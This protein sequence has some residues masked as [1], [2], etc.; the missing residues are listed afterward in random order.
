LALPNSITIDDALHPVEKRGIT[1]DDALAARDAATTVS[2][3]VPRLEATQKLAND[4]PDPR[5]LDEQG[6]GDTSVG[7]DPFVKTNAPPIQP[8]TDFNLGARIKSDLVEDPQTKRKV[9]AKSLFPNDPNG[10]TRIGFIDDIPVFVND[11]GQL[12]RVAPKSS[13]F[14]S[15]VIANAPEAIAGV[16][17][18]LSGMPVVGA[19]LGA[20][21][22]HG[23]K[24]AIAGAVFDEPQT[25]GGNLRG[26]AGEGVLNAAAGLAGKG[27]ASVI[28]RGKIV[29]FTPADVK[30]AEQARVLIKN[31]TGIDVD[32][33][34]ASGNNKLIA[35]RAYAA[36]YPGKSAELVQ[37]SEEA[38]KGQLD[39]AVNRVLNQIATTSPAEVAGIK[40]INAAGAVIELA[41]GARDKAVAPLYE[42]AG[43]N[44]LSVAAVEDLSFDPLVSRAAQQV[45]N[46]PVYQRKLTGM[47]S[48]SVAYWHQVKRRLDAGYQTATTSGNKTAARE[49]ADAA[50]KLNEKLAAASPE[51]KAANEAYAKAT[52]DTIEPLE[53]SAIGVLARVKDPKAATVAARIFND[54]NITASEIR[55][56][57]T[58][59]ENQDPEAW[60]GLVRQ[61]I[62][63]NWNKALK[64]T[65][66]GSAVNPA[67][68]LRQALVGTPGD[69][70]KAAAMMPTGALQAFEDL[71]N[72]AK[73]LS[74]TPT[75]GSNTMRDT[76]IGNQLKG[77]G[78]VIFKWLTSP[79]AA[80]ANAAEQRAVDKNTLALTEAILDPTKQ[81]QLR[82]VVKMGDGA[83]KAFVLS[84]ILG[85]QITDRVVYG[86]Y[87]HKPDA[88]TQ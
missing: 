53:N 15:G 49:Y 40:G 73:A 58:S 18:S 28:G 51:Y 79:R 44:Q 33:A 4:Y 41:K 35:L 25:I 61:W 81:K 9:I 22:A 43:K 42:A 76:E 64:E 16:V 83:R 46:D 48:D 11:Q 78:A 3:D 68:K 55:A 72:A 10:H 52:K 34:Q 57:R 38:Q 70:A 63:Q 75:A 1:Y 39:A 19:A 84:S 66:T 7:I 59:I 14:V 65:Q 13:G 87:D 88:L 24:R 80:V 23:I 45:K 85:E 29:D 37:A 2:V 5:N 86:V 69:R 26:M 74:R 56:T 71:M 17:G 77:Q 62:S 8:A 6:R 36:R 20:A 32:L 12:Q 27:V 82:Q 50:A 30:T 21:G 47:G 31:S 54:P 67:G 60:N